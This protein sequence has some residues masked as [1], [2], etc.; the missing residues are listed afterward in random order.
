MS[1][2][3]KQ[4]ATTASE[5]SSPKQVTQA[6]S[7]LTKTPLIL[8]AKLSNKSAKP[9]NSSFSAPLAVDGALRACANRKRANETTQLEDS[10]RS[11]GV[12]CESDT[13]AS[14]LE[15]DLESSY[16]CANDQ[17]EAQQPRVSTRLLEQSKAGKKPGRRTQKDGITV[18]VNRDSALD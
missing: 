8:T 6:S 7:E 2:S 5:C 16:A 10:K 18:L 11:R 13:S 4:A 1:S 15:S 3:E 14:E 9:Q 17:N 12:N